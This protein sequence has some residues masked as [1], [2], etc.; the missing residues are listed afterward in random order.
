MSGKIFLST[1]S[2]AAFEPIRANVEGAE[3]TGAGV[4]TESDRAAGDAIVC[5]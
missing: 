2:H 4:L 3:T 5:S 1:E